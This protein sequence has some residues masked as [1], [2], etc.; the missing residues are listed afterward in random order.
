MF[1]L[2]DYDEGSVDSMINLLPQSTG[3]LNSDGS[4]AKASKDALVPGYK[5]KSAEDIL[6]DKFYEDLLSFGSAAG[7]RRQT[8]DKTHAIF[9]SNK[10][11]TLSAKVQE[12]PV[13]ELNSAFLSKHRMAKMLFESDLCNDLNA[14]CLTLLVKHAE[15]IFAW[16]TF[17]R[18][19]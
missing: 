1:D 2:R 5:A 15:K 13:F 11:G 8:E 16:N 6:D 12:L 17:S 19:N 14:E 3:S 9:Q 4:S 10:R 7:S 18:V